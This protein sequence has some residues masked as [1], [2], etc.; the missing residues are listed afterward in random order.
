MYISTAALDVLI[1]G[2]NVL[3]SSAKTF[4][5]AFAPPFIATYPMSGSFSFITYG[6]NT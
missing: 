3:V 1:S 2:T 6:I 5:F 4:V